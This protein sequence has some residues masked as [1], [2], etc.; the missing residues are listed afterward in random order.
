MSSD[1]ATKNH[2]LISTGRVSTPMVLGRKSRRAKWTLLILDQSF[3]NPSG[4]RLQRRLSKY[5]ESRKLTQPQTVS[6]LSPKNVHL[7]LTYHKE[8]QIL[9]ICTQLGG[10]IISN[11]ITATIFSALTHSNHA[12]FLCHCCH[13][14]PKEETNEEEMKSERA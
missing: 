5:E 12:W 14:F 11:Y 10:E 6:A 13:F 9:P 8:N 7:I 2:T 3:S 1:S 4:G